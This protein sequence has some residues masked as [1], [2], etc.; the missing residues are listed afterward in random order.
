VPFFKPFKAHGYFSKTG[1]VALTKKLSTYKSCLPNSMWIVFVLLR[2]FL[3][4][5]VFNGL[6]FHRLLLQTFELALNL[7]HLDVYVE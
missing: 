5:F 6:I 7:R 2:M 1:Q 4:P 3:C